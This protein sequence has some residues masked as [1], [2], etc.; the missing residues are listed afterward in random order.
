MA[1]RSPKGL[2]LQLGCGSV[3]PRGWINVDATPG[4]RLA[5]ISW[6]GS[7]LAERAG[8]RVT[9][10]PEVRV[11]DLRRRLPWRDGAA[12]V[13]Y[14]A[15]ALAH[16]RRDD[17]CRFLA[18]CHRVLAPGGVLRVV[19]PDLV[20]ILSGYEKGEIPAVD[21]LDH[22]GAGYEE[23]GDGPWNRR[24]APFFRQPHRCMYDAES[25]LAAFRTAGFEDA[26][27]HPPELSRIR[28]IAEVERPERTARSLIVEAVRG[29]EAGAIA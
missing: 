4:A 3:Q 5:R 28:E 22:L 21:L 14:S 16:L 24:L 18:E 20:P 11:H 23:P 17:G 27:L 12:A 7:W 26:R 2:L 6:L 13:V 25:L 9:E 10:A 1:R 15:H 29:Q 19:V 8:L